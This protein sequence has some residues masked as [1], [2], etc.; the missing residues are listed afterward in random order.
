MAKSFI[1]WLAHTANKG[2]SEV[3]F[4]LFDDIEDGEYNG[5]SVMETFDIF[6]IAFNAQYGNVK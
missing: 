4:G 2:A 5:V 6:T 3:G 1:L